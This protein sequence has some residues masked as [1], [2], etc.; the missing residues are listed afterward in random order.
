MRTASD[1]A[2]FTSVFFEHLP[3]F[4][5][6]RQHINSIAQQSCASGFERPPNP[7]S[8]RLIPAWQVGNKKQPMLALGVHVADSTWL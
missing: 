3:R 6:F 2:N 8:K 5:R 7:H 4:R 1:T